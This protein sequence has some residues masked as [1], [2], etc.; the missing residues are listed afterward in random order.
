DVASG[1]EIKTITGHTASIT[2]VAFSPDGLRMLTG[3]EDYTAKLW[4][5]SPGHEGKAILNLKGHTQ[6]VTSVRF[7]RDGHYVCTGSRD[8]TGMVWL[9]TA[10]QEP[11]AAGAAVS[12]NATK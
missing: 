6:E 3:S 10:W 9:T 11:R 7:S 12:Q 2:S 5:A 8:G 1:K 4:D